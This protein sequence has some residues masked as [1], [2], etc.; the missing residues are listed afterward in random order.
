MLIIGIIV[1]ILGISILLSMYITEGALNL[2]IVG[3]ETNRCTNCGHEFK[4]KLTHCPK[5]AVKLFYN[6]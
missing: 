1:F 4:G 2:G 6:K 3:D 5:C